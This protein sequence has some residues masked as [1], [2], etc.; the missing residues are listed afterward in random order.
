ME[1]KRQS[2][3][4]LP[5]DR[6]SRMSKLATDFQNYS[7]NE[8]I[9]AFRKAMLEHLGSVPGVIEADG[10]AHRFST[11]G[12][13]GDLSGRYILHLDGGIPAGYFEC[14]RQGIKRTWRAGRDLVPALSAQERLAIHEQTELN[15]ARKQRAETKKQAE[16]AD[17]AVNIWGFARSAPFDYPYL[18]TKGIK[19][20]NAKLYNTALIIPMYNVFGRL[21][22]LQ[23]IFSDGSKRFL[24]GGRKRGLFTVLGGVKLA[25]STR[26]LVVEGW[27]TGCTVSALEP[28]VPVIVA[29]DAG[30]LAPVVEVILGKYHDLKLTIVADDD[31]ATAKKTGHNTGLEKALAV[32]AQYQAVTVVVPDFPINAPIELSDINDL[33]VWRNQ[34]RGATDGA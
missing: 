22:N 33:V 28:G 34:H 10:A 17:Q 29:F 12:K 25:A 14:H 27:A 2:P 30:N 23:R 16:T 15:K 24:P 4:G 18:I 1:D 13:K 3:T 32:A 26:A 8:I 5:T 31:R 11:N 20:N 6:A 7:A 9:D 21:W 19:P